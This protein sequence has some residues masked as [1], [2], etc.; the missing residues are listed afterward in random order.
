MQEGK[1]TLFGVQHAWTAIMAKR[2]WEKA[3]NFKVKMETDKGGLCIFTTRNISKRGSMNGIF[4]EIKRK[5]C[6]K[7]MKVRNKYQKFKRI[8]RIRKRKT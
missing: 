6:C 4:I 8:C 7:I 1:W 5:K 2:K 3:I